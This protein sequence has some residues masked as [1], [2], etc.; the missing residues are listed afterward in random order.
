VGDFR[1]LLAAASARGEIVELNG[2]REAPEEAYLA[3]GRF[4]LRNC[5]L[6]VAIWDGEPARGVGGTGE[7]V[8]EAGERGIPIV[9]ID[10]QPPHHISLISPARPGGTL[11][12]SADLLASA[13]A[14][15]PTAAALASGEA[16][17]GANAKRRRLGKHRMAERDIAQR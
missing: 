12:Y 13:I 2:S 8:A 10:T 9:H 7:I 5:E 16:K 11:D 4:V 15:A 3:V 14:S 6:V 1:D 17:L